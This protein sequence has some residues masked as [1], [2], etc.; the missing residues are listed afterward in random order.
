MRCHN[1]ELLSG[2]DRRKTHSIAPVLPDL[3]TTGQIRVPAP[4]RQSI[5]LTKRKVP[6]PHHTQARTHTSSCLQP[7]TVQRGPQDYRHLVRPVSRSLAPDLLPFRARTYRINTVAL[8]ARHP[9]PC[10]LCLLSPSRKQKVASRPLYPATHLH[11]ICSLTAAPALTKKE[12]VTKLKTPSHF[13]SL[14]PPPLAF[15][16]SNAF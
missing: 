10:L 14:P 1:N 3:I 7:V 8:P 5:M 13:V 2:N 9:H 6:A 11:T 4:A 12:K 15:I 16:I